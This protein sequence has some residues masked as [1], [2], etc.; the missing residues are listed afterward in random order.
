MR[1]P[2]TNGPTTRR[3][4]CRYV[5]G[6]VAIACKAPAQQT[7]PAGVITVADNKATFAVD[8]CR[9]MESVAYTFIQE[10]G[11][12]ITFE[13]APLVWPGDFVDVTRNLSAGIHAYDPRG[14]RLEF[15]YD[16]GP[17][18]TA[19]EDPGSVLR[20]AIAA[21]NKTGFPGRYRLLPEDGYFQIVPAAH[22]NE[23][24]LLE[25]IRSPLDSVVTVDGGGR[26]PEP[27]LQDLTRA[28]ERVSGYRVV[29]GRTPFLQGEQPRIK[30]LFTN[31]QARSIL[32]ALIQ[33]TGKKRV[34][35][36]MYWIMHRQY[37]LSIV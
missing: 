7:S 15:S 12:R 24:G 14:G 8:Y 28:M 19:P 33:A 32:R 23:A 10:Y 1:I 2:I 30:R 20:T 18:G 22:R 31:T 36:L 6:T 29:V 11:W 9:P 13:E 34:W 26:F 5:A 16:L 27:V 25:S 4:F 37:F 17:N 35:Y 21:Y 3:R